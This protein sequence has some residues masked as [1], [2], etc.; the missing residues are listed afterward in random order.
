MTFSLFLIFYVLAC[1]VMML[2]LLVIHKEDN[3]PLNRWE[4]IFYVVMSYIPFLNIYTAYFLV[5][6]FLDI[7]KNSDT[8]Y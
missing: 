3:L 4:V 1:T 7:G 6:V 8:D 5:Q 2:G